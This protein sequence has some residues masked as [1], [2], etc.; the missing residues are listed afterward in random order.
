MQSPSQ[1]SHDN[2]VQPLCWASVVLDGF[3]LVALAVVFPVLL[4]DHV[5]GLTPGSASAIATIGLVGMT[6]GA[7]LVG[8]IAESVG[9]RRA[10]II[11]VACF[12]L[13]TLLS[14]AAPSAAVFTVLRFLAGLGL[15]GCI[16]V[17]VTL[18]AEHK[19]SRG[20]SS[21]A[22]TLLMTG[23]N[24]GAVLCAMLGMVLVPELG[25]RALIVAGALPAFV[26][27]PLL[28][29]Y[30][31]ESEVFYAVRRVER[32]PTRLGRAALAE[33]FRGRLL[34]ASLA[35]WVATFMGLMLIYGLNTW[36]PEIMHVAGYSLGH[37]L[38]FLLT[39]NLGA[40]LGYL[41][42]GRLAD[43][44][45]ART[46][47][48][49]WFCGSATFLALFSLPLPE[50]A[51]YVVLFLAGFFV[52]S[53]QALTYAYTQRV[54]PEHARAVGVGWTAGVGR[55]GAICGPL[56]GGALLSTGAAYPWGFFVFALVGALG[57]AAAWAVPAAT[58]TTKPL[59]VPTQAQPA[60]T[61]P[62][63][64]NGVHSQVE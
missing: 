34:R 24:V 56:L 22:T 15:G 64:A 60:T 42:G 1:R 28:V 37:S 51:L 20:Q 14:A 61:A 2:W 18:V 58:T 55:L 36:L 17:A 40:I 31:P 16:P 3:D 45:G 19:A 35:F 38:G 63:G 9:R 27:V 59:T 41:V 23:F 53:S 43:R 29:R 32:R 7:L 39:L 44:R 48:I 46:A 25:W 4:G 54:Y 52:F 49:A 12:S 57:A 30:L 26:L 62:A 10:L 33:I 8:T 13:F 47:T 50:A 21:S 6:V 5:W 11:S